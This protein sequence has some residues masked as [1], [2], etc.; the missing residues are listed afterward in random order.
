MIAMVCDYVACYPSGKRAGK[1]IH[2]SEPQLELQPAFKQPLYQ[3]G[4]ALF[5]Q[6][7]S[8]LVFF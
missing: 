5:M 4:Y 2:A 7:L 3:M 8:S 1:E 6:A